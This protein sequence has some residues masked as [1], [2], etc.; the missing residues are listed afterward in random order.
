M[1][2]MKSMSKVFI[3]LGLTHYSPTDVC[4]VYT[5]VGKANKAVRR[6]KKEAST[7]GSMYSFYDL[8]EIEDWDVKDE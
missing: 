3:V 6:F 4:G 7:T 5:T 1:S 8:F 2:G